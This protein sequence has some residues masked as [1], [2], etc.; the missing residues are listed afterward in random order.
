MAKQNNP[1]KS[2]EIQKKNSESESDEAIPA[3]ILK[4]VNSIS[5][6]IL[7]KLSKEERKELA[8]TVIMMQ[9]RSHSGPLP[10]PETFEGYEAVLPGAAERILIMA[11]KQQ[12][13]R[14][15][16]EKKHLL[17]QLFQSKLGQ[18]FGLIIAIVCISVGA[19]LVMN[20][21]ETAGIILFGSTLIGL[22]TI[23]VIGK[24]SQTEKE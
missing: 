11:E 24:K 22:V 7:K 13:H 10:S 15:D 19:F 23:F 2:Q 18:I 12:D 5:P 3:E 21:H 16:L 6:N 9:M 17:E 14:M 1:R 4:E 8:S 20:E